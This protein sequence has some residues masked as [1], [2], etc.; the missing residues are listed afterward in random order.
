M[1][2]PTIKKIPYIQRQRKS[3]N[4]MVGGAKSSLE[5]NP[6]PTRDTQRAQKKP[7]A[8]Q[9]PETPTEIEPNL[10]LSVECLLQRCRSAVACH[11]DRASGCSRPE[12]HSM[13]HK[14]SW[15]RSPLT[16]RRATKQMIH[17]LQNT[18]KKVLGPTTDFPT[19]GSGKGTEN[20]QG[21][22]LG[23]PVGLDYRAST[24]LGKQTLGSRKPCAH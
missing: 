20:P 4:K 14:P 3:P 17:K 16:P 5:S 22:W 10:P 11:R 9:D 7:C 18:V 1:L 2:D 15:R 13:W 21:I 12:T 23:R 24:G 19:W 8:H 6:I